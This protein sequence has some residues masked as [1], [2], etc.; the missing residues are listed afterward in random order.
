MVV[1]GILAILA[2]MATPSFRPIAERWRVKQGVDGLQSSLYFARSEAIKRGGNI[3]IRKEPTGTNGCLLAAGIN[4]WDCGWFVF[5][6]TNGD[7][8]RQA[9]EDLL[10]RFSGPANTMITRIG[11][12][13]II[14]LDRWG[15]IDSVFTGFSLVPVS[16]PTTDTAARGVCMSA[17]GRVRV[18]NP[19]EIPCTS[20]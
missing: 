9:S 13:E 1:V 12:G 17:G 15:R 4:D 19:V 5:V 10:Q 8:A 6:D 3:V 18:I 14:R 16:K 7:G 2:A 20:G 11:G